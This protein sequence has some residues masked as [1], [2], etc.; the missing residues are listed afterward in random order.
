MKLFVFFA[1]TVSGATL[2]EKQSNLRGKF[3]F[4]GSTNKFIIFIRT[5]CLFIQNFPQTVRLSR[6]LYVIPLLRVK[7][8]PLTVTRAIRLFALW[9]LRQ[10][11]FLAKPYSKCGDNCAKTKDSVRASLCSHTAWATGRYL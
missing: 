4:K 2:S 6:G 5:R 11:K 9:K 3:P 1:I 8:L 10:S 7:T